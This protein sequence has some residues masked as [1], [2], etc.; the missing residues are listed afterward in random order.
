MTKQKLENNPKSIGDSFPPIDW[1]I[2]EISSP[3]ANSF[4]AAGK[5]LRRSLAKDSFLV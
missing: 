2:R 5:G 4:F 3:P 1:M